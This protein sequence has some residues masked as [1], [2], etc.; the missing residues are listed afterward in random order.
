[1]AS[2]Y[3]TAADCRAIAE[4]LQWCALTSSTHEGPDAKEAYQRQSRQMMNVASLVEADPNYFTERTAL[5]AA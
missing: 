5:R 1:M 3:P 2:D 4:T